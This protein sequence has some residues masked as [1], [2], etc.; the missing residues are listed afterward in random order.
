MEFK[1]IPNTTNQMHNRISN[2]P[3]SKSLHQIQS[4]PS[5]QTPLR[6]SINPYF[7]RALVGSAVPDANLKKHN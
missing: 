1:S 2:T 3:K 6:E 4:I 7:I 5:N